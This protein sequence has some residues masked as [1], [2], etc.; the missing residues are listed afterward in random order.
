MVRSSGIPRGRGVAGITHIIGARAT[1][2]TVKRVTESKGSLDATTET[3]AAHTE[4]VW[5]FDPTET[6]I[7]A[8]A[9]ERVTGDLGGLAVADGNVDIQHGDRLTHG[10]VEY[11]VDT[12]VGVPDDARTEYWQ[13]TLLRRH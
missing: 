1:A 2:T 12:V 10:G 8:S 13:I 4:D 7:Q 6:N 3:T 5:L 9:G 11:E